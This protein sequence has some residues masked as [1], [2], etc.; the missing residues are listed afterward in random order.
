MIKAK[1][2]GFTIAELSMSM[3]FIAFILIAIATLIVY[4]ISLYQ[5]GL[6]LRSVNN[7]GL[8]IIDEFTRTI[9]GS[10]NSKPDC[11]V[12]SGSIKSEC[13]TDNGYHLTYYQGNT[14]V[15]LAKASRSVD[16]VSINV[17]SWGMFCTGTYSY[18]WNSGY[19]STNN[20]TYKTSA[21]AGN[22]S[23]AIYRASVNGNSDFRFVRYNDPSREVCKSAIDKT[24][25]YSNPGNTITVSSEIYSTRRE[26]LTNTSERQLAIYDLRVYPPAY[27]TLTS[28][29]FYSGS[30]VI[31][32]I[33][34]S[35]NIET[36]SDVCKE[37]P[38]GLSTDFAYCAINKFNFAVR[39]SGA[40]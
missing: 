11:S 29:A 18:V 1:K 15:Y 14:T 7:T 38:D 37:T 28:H 9:S 21:N 2:K 3:A 17:P 35:V 25:S 34:G 22:N 36:T 23:L 4:A 24:S 20:G 19:L 32:T 26:L 30:F 40:K 31:G 33:A 12:F 8:E 39:A 16:Q 10:I 27:H 13:E 6:T 5:K